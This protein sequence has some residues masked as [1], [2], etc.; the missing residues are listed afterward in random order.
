MQSKSSMTS[1]QRVL[2]TLSHREPDRV[3][4]FLFL[5]MYGAK[6]LGISIEDYFSKVDNVVEG[7]LEMRRR[8]RHDSLLA[9][10][11]A[12]AELEAWGGETIFYPDGPPNAAAPILA[13]VEA[14]DQLVLPDISKAQSLQRTL[15]VIEK[16]KLH[17]ADEVPIIGVVLS[18][19]SM[20]I[21]QLGFERYLQLLHFDKPRFNRLMWLNEKFCGQWANA[22]LAAGATAIGYF[23]PLASPTMIP[24]ET[25]LASGYQTFKRMLGEINGAIAV[26]M[27]S[28]KTLSLLPDLV[29]SGAALMGFSAEENIP[30]IKA[31]CRN[32]VTLLGNFN[33][34]AM[35]H[36]DE[37][38][39]KR[40]VK[41]IIDGAGQGG[42]LIVADNHGEIP[43]QTP[44]QV[45]YWIGEAIEQFGSYPLK[46]N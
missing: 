15:Q 26:H 18:P 9:F 1:M 28:G 16:L 36:W 45:L 43:W 42:G 40:Q 19:F 34:I 12:S 23:D 27:A 41:L 14:I 7:Q 5:T 10:G 38:E 39:T 35:R 8:Y 17:V 30:D 2:T 46:V 3:P 44:E 25:Y 31:A 20:P 6:V 24:R 29:N 11:Y 21:L 4:Y 33:G 22:Q 37:Q 13:N 32:K